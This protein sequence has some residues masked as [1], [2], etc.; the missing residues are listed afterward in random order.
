LAS[1]FSREIVASDFRTILLENIAFPF[2]TFPS[3]SF[4]IHHK[5]HAIMW[6]KDVNDVII[7]L[8]VALSSKVADKL[9]PILSTVVVETTSTATLLW[10][11]LVE[12]ILCSFRW[13]ENDD[14]SISYNEYHSMPAR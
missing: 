7:D 14:P 9:I 11:R 3:T 1:P 13:R 10:Q 6:P 8:H 12:R 4:T 2:R 5:N